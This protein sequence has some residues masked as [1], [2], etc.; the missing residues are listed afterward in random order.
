MQLSFPQTNELARNIL[1]T[2]IMYLKASEDVKISTLLE[3][4]GGRGCGSQNGPL[5]CAKIEL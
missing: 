5:M 1:H 3:K 4:M 2:F